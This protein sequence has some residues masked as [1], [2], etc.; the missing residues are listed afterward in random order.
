[1]PG[2]TDGRVLTVGGMSIDTNPCNSFM[3]YNIETDKWSSLPPM[4]TARYATFSFLINNKLYVLGKGLQMVTMQ[5][6]HVFGTK[7]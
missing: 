4:P 1:M 7:I 6:T 2:D 3:S 5:N